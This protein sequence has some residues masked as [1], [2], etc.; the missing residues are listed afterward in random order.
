MIKKGYWIVTVEVSDGERYKDYVAA[1]TPAYKE[2]GAK[3]LIRGGENIAV[4]GEWNSRNVLV[5]FPSY[6]HA[7]DCYN[8]QVYAKA[9]T[10]RQEASK[11]RLIIVEG[12]EQ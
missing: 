3:F 1:A 7:K 10:I 6:Q 5:E 8:S 9:R 2:Y 12:F 11:G 4:E